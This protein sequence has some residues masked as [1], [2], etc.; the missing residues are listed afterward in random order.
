LLIKNNL[1]DILKKVIDRE[2]LD[3]TLTNALVSQLHDKDGRMIERI[4]E[5]LLKERLEKE[6]SYG[7]FMST[8]HYNMML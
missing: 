1:V 5:R 3:P 6:D 8:L 7:N 2:K 4:Y